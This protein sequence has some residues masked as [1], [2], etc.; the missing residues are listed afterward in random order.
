MYLKGVGCCK[1]VVGVCTPGP[2]GPEGPTGPQGA[3][4]PSGPSLSALL[5]Y[6]GIVFDGVSPD[7]SSNELTFNISDTSYNGYPR[8]IDN[9]GLISFADL[10][11]CNNCFIEMYSHCDASTNDSGSRNYINLDLSGITVVPNSLSVVDLDTRS[12]QKGS[13]AHL[14][15]GPSM[16]KIVDTSTINNNL[17]IN[18]SN[19]Y[20]LRVS[21][22]HDYE[23]D[24]LKL[25]IK[26]IQFDI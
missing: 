12:V 20:K 10:S 9:S 21:V 14:T 13:L 6:E 24:E 18:T 16:Y 17:S 8:F 25:I 11:G 19:T 5:F 1:K 15:F 26:V 4:G 3:T 7:G 23:I 2:A 22:G